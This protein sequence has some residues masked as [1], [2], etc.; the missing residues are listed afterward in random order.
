MPEIAG[1]IHELVMMGGS[2]FALGNVTPA[3]EFNVYVD[4]HAAEPRDINA[5][6]NGEDHAGFEHV[7]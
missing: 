3:A 6:F 5:R 7:P 1:K 4:P 2:G